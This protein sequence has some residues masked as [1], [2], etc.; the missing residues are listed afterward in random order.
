M[1]FGSGR[2]GGKGSSDLYRCPLQNGNYSTIESLGDSVNTPDNEYEPFIA[3]D[4]SYVIFMSTVPR[5]LANADFY[6]SYQHKGTWGKSQKLRYP[7]NSDATE[8]SPKITSDGKYFLFSSA[9][10]K[11]QHRLPKP[12]TIRE[13]N[14]CIR[15]AGNGLGDIYYIDLS[16][17]NI[18][19]Y[20]N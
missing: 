14:N 6:I 1:Y 15:N 10:N 2:A 11:L 13:L 3:P 9:R 16:V 18:H 8:F 17:L 5:G 7:F 19:K 20:V 12:A 4:E